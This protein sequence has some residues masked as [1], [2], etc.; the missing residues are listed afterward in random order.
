MFRDHIDVVGR[1]I[2]GEL[3]ESL[4]RCTAASAT[5]IGVI[6]R[7]D[8]IE[9]SGRAKDLLRALDPY[10]IRVE[11]VVEWPGT[12]LVGGRTSLHHLYRLTPESLGLILRAADDLFA[13]VNPDLPE[14]LHFLRADGS[15]VLGTIAQEDDAWIEFDEVE[16]D[17]LLEN[18]PQGLKVALAR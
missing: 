18:A 2:V 11:S 9:L 17:D 16:F 3:Y 14:D 15:T 8:K 7:S 5:A 6:V 1:P 12:R 10:V 13:W 4:L